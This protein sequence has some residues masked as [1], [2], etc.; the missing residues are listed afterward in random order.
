MPFL[1]DYISGKS[2]PDRAALEQ[3]FVNS[4]ITPGTKY[5][6]VPVGGTPDLQRLLRGK[7]CWPIQDEA[8]KQG[9]IKHIVISDFTLRADKDLQ[10]HLVNYLPH[11]GDTHRLFI[12]QDDQLVKLKSPLDLE[13][14]DY[15]KIAPLTVQ[16]VNKRLFDTYGISS[17]QST[18]L[19]ITKLREA[20]Y[21]L[22]GTDNWINIGALES[23]P[24]LLYF[25]KENGTMNLKIEIN[26]EEY[27]LRN[28]HGILELAQQINSSCTGCKFKLICEQETYSWLA[29][30]EELI[31]LLD[32]EFDLKI[33]LKEIGEDKGVALL[34]SNLMK[35]N[36]LRLGS[37]AEGCTIASIIG[38]AN[39]AFL[40]KVSMSRSYIFSQ[41]D[42]TLL[43]NRAPILEKIIFSN[44]IIKNVLTET[45]NSFQVNLEHLKEI[46]FEYGEVGV[47]DI[48]S[49]VQKTP[50]LRKMS[51]HACEMITAGRQT[52]ILN[53]SQANLAYLE[54]M[55]FLNQKVPVEVIT[56]LLQRAPNLRRIVINSSSGSEFSADK[57]VEALSSSQINL[58]HLE[59]ISLEE[60]RETRLSAKDITALLQKAPNVRKVV[61]SGCKNIAKD[62]F[63]GILNKLQINFEFLENIYFPYT[64]V[65]AKDVIALLQKAPNLKEINLINCTGITPNIF[66]EILNSLQVSFEH[67]EKIDLSYTKVSA[68]DVVSLLQ[69]APNLR[70]INLSNC[71]EIT[72]NIF[73]EILNSLQVSFEHLE[74]INL[75]PCNVSARDV[76]ALLQKAPNLKEINLYSCPGITPN[77]FAEILNSLQV[78]FEHLRR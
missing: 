69:K 38:Q 39:L 73:A 45:L 49:L 48:I 43:F 61:L 44:S 50:N 51:F 75:S 66:T 57:L 36:A 1:M 9:T 21:L 10:T 33:K 28:P 56:F 64:N 30:H 37:V 5:T 55:I 27:N 13:K 42:L 34:L 53:S 71:P 68:G 31:K 2:L 6:N 72:P 19:D 40:K 3:I 18:V 76:I 70:K 65:S 25:L 67:L 12:L 59:E 22:N 8:R 32:Y 47:E 7:D 4:V 62:E 77:I 78:S 52:E 14:I 26:Q 15:T 16:Q 63:V 54:E 58:K 60:T 35:L 74:K 46:E 11:V 17:E 23:I 20:R 24:N 29:A 41:A